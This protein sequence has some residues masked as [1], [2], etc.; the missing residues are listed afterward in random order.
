VRALVARGHFSRPIVA[1]ELTRILIGRRDRILDR[2]LT[3][4]SPLTAPSIEGDGRTICL[5]D[6]AV[7]S[8][9]RT[10]RDRRYTATAW[11]LDPAR[12]RSVALLEAPDGICVA[13]SPDPEGDASYLIVDVVASSR[14]AETT[15]PLRVHLHERAGRLTVA[16]LER[17]EHVESSAP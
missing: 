1:S 10:A 17:L 2:W 5:E 14:D 15:L 4:L 16:G 13:V 11:A 6:R 3:R 8:G 7:S 9:F 12:S